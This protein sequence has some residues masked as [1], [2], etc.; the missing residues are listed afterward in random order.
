MKALLTPI[1][2]TELGQVILRPGRDLMPIFRGRVVVT[3][4]SVYQRKLPAGIITEE[5]Q[6]I[7][8]DPEWAW[9]LTHERVIK[10]AG[11]RGEVIRHVRAHSGCQW[12]GDYHHPEN[13]IMKYGHSAIKLC[14][15]HDNELRQL[16]TPELQKIADSNA[17]KSVARAVVRRLK[18]RSCHQITV[19]EVCW[20]SVLVNVSD[21][22]PDSVMREALRLPPAEPVGR[23]K[24]ECDI[25]WEVLPEKE[26]EPYIERVKSVMALFV[27]G[28][29]PAGYMKRPKL[30]R[31]ESEQ[32]TRWVK[33]QECSGCRRPADDPHHIIN[34]GLSGT[35]TKPHDLFVIPLCRRCHDELHRDVEGWEREHGSQV[36]LLVR[37]LNRAL[38]IGA[39]TKS[40]RGV[41]DA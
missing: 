11:G 24:R 40:K 38:G 32:Y 12:H 19:H 20:W 14:W 10:A 18:L 17:A 35:G 3:P 9:F 2:V 36:E 15:H 27:D 6:P 31:W 23:G 41:E 25:R 28:D 1:V 4:E 21:L 30:Q 13:T 26:L 33:T 37:F 39:I 5:A 29:P 7:L 22:L 8:D 34:Q 16:T